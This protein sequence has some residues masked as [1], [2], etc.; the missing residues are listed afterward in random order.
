MIKPQ[1][2]FNIRFVGHIARKYNFL[3]Y[4]LIFLLIEGDKFT[5]SGTTKNF[6][7]YFE[8]FFE[9]KILE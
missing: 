8:S 2:S 9:T 7:K 5:P 6:L 1:H 3:I 4:L